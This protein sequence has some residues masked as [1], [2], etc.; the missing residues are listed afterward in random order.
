MARKIIEP[1]IS[2]DEER[3]RYYLTVDLGRD[4]AGHR[5]R[6]CRTF[7]TLTAARAARRS[8]LIGQERAK[9]AP[10]RGYTLEEWLNCWMDT[11]VC[12]NGQRPRHTPIGK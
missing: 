10:A 9:A 4:D 12:P 5:R 6:Q 3:R 8:S 11:I 7:S 1:N 2:Y